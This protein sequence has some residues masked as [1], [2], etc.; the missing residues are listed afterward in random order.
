[1]SAQLINRFLRERRTGFEPAT[2]TL[3]KVVLFVRL[4]PLGPLKCDSVHPG[5][6]RSTQSAAV[7]E[8]STTDEPFGLRAK[9]GHSRQAASSSSG[10]T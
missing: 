2:L 5:S 4:A 9:I 10:V 1:V 3:G 7:V 8:R 6:S